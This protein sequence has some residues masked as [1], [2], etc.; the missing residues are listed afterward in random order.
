M[1]RIVDI[2]SR[3]AGAG[4]TWC[5][6]QALCLPAPMP[7]WIAQACAAIH[8]SAWQPCGNKK[9]LGMQSKLHSCRSARIRDIH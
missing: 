7:A 3:C 6:S 2:D 4:T 5:R 9:G 8:G 1:D